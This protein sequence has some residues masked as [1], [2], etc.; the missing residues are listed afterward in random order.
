MEKRNI[1]LEMLEQEMTGIYDLL[2]RLGLTADRSGFFHMSYA[3]YLAVRQSERLLLASKWL[4]PEVAKH[5]GTTQALVERDI[6][7]MADIAWNTNRSLLERLANKPLQTKPNAAQ[8]MAI[9]S[10]RLVPTDAA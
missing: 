1:L 10:M 8:F 6:R 2:Y 5:Y 4:Y 3:V 7:R 9:L